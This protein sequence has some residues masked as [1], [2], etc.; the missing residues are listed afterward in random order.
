MPPPTGAQPTFTPETE[1]EDPEND[2]DLN[3]EDIFN[4]DL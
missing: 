4:E 2:M 3:T 1:Q